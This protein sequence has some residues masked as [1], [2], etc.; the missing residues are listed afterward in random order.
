MEER[1]GMGLATRRRIRLDGGHRHLWLLLS[2]VRGG[3]GFMKASRGWRE[4]V[5]GRNV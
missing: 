2:L 4:D 1:R 3:V 5:G